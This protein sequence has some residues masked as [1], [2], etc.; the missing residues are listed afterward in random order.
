MTI[1]WWCTSMRL[2]MGCSLELRM[3]ST[4]TR[5]GIMNGFRCRNWY[6]NSLIQWTRNRGFI[7]NSC[8]YL[9]LGSMKH[10]WSIIIPVSR[11]ICQ[12]GRNN[13]RLRH[14]YSSVILN[15]KSSIAK[16]LRN[17]NILNRDAIWR[18]SIAIRGSITTFWSVRLKR[19]KW[20]SR[21]TKSPF[22][23]KYSMITWSWKSSILKGCSEY[24][25]SKKTSR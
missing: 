16:L 3:R 5:E 10:I 20:Y 7:S 1:C 24:R 18:S 23:K 15:N 8:K 19:C 17:S 21:T 22:S 13:S 9:W 12:E 14:S 25:R 2:S 4:N 11:S 6:N